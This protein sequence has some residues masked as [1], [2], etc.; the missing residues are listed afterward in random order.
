M[1]WSSEDSFLSTQFE[2]GDI[3]GSSPLSGEDETNENVDFFCS[4]L[5]RSFEQ[6]TPQVEKRCDKR[7]RQEDRFD[8]LCD[9]VSEWIKKQAAQSQSPP[10][11]SRNADFLRVLD[12]YLPTHS[13]DE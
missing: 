13:E 10:P 12:E 2:S 8:H 11:V 5:P 1:Q 6:S 3:F 9:S 7:K 4:E